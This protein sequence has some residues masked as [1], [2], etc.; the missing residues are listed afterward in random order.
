MSNPFIKKQLDFIVTNIGLTDIYEIDKIRY[1]LEVFYGEFSKLLIMIIFAIL[2]GKLPAFI[3]MI[4]LLMLIR[5]FIGGSH[6][7]TFLSCMIKSNLSFIAIY[8]LSNI[9]HSINII[10]HLVL[11]LVFI[12][13]IRSFK[14][15]NPLRNTIKT[16]YKNLKFKNII[17]FVLLV[18]F[19]LSN[20]LLSNYYINCGLLIIIYIIIDFLKEVFKHEK[21]ISS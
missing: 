6:S 2:L 18:W 5:P 7:K 13:I 11:I 12:I 16:E 3:L 9:L 14:P 15:V 17:T 20:L 8:Y 19:I 21:K 4:T 1:G 10:I